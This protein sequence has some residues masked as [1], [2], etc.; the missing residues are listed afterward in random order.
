MVERDSSHCV[1]LTSLLPLVES[2]SRHC[3]QNRYFGRFDDRNISKLE[4]AYSITLLPHTASPQEGVSSNLAHAP[5]PH[6]R[7]GTPLWCIR[8]RGTQGRLVLLTSR[9][10]RAVAFFS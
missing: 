9:S 2:C 10:M 3:V 8:R 6:C 4:R 5:P 1:A 7:L